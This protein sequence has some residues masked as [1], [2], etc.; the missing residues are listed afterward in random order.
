MIDLDPPFRPATPDDAAALA[1]L[2]HFASQGLALYVWTGIAGANGDP[3][4]VGRE[5]ARRETGSFSYRNAVVVE[6]PAGEVAAALIGYALPDRPEPISDHAGDVRASAGT[7]EPGTRHLVRERPC[8]LPRPARQGAWP[9]S[10]RYRRPPRRC[11][12]ATW[13]QHHRLRR[14]YPCTAALSAL[15]L[16]GGRAAQKGEGGSARRR[17]GLDIADQSV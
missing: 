15:R 5:R 10:A 4:Q 16:P 17:H 7:G 6:D 1:D 9:S 14:Q 2:V 8:R 13:P 3:W 11:R 12:R